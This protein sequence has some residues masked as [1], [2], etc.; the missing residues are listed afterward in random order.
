MGFFLFI[1]L[2]LKSNSAVTIKPTPYI[3]IFGAVFC[4]PT[5]KGD[6]MSAKYDLKAIEEVRKPYCELCGSPAYGWPHHI[7]TRGAGGKEDKW[8]LIQLCGECHVG[9]ESVHAG[10]ISRRTLIEIVAKREGMTV[11]EIY[12]KQGWLIDD[13]F[14]EEI[15]IESPVAGKTFDEILDLYLF[16]LEKGQDSMWERAAVITVMHDFMKLTPRQI[17]SAVG[18]SA[19]LCRKMVRTY[20]AFSE[21]ERI[22]FL[23]F[24]HHQIAA[25]TADPITWLNTAADK[26]LSTRQLQE[27]INDTKLEP[28]AKKDA[29]WE[30]AEKA[31]RL[32]QESLAADDESAEWLKLELQKL[33]Y[34]ELSISA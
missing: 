1:R 30:K 34:P 15:K 25:S 7:K 18:C 28:E 9:K 5:K 32:A 10:K 21:E 29:A 12:N 11:E 6:I 24:R 23:S 13:K 14:P 22:P 2:V 33:I 3:L 26:Q 8:N 4:S 16:C 20:N 31:L 27:Q 19:S 17:A